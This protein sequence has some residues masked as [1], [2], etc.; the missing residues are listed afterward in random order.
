MNSSKLVG[1]MTGRSAAF[2]PS[3]NGA[4]DLAFVPGLD[5][6]HLYPEAFHRGLRLPDVILREAWIVRI[7]KEGNPG[8]VGKNL[9]QQLHPLGDK[10]DSHKSDSRFD[11]QAGRLFTE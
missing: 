7:H 2:S 11:A 5:N 9:M 8:G 1:C 3:D 10:L 6:D 4:F